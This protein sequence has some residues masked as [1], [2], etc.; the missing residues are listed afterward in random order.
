MEANGPGVGTAREVVFC[1]HWSTALVLNARV[2]SQTCY[3]TG[4][5]GKPLSR[6]LLTVLEHIDDRSSKPIPKFVN[7]HRKGHFS[8]LEMV[9]TLK[10]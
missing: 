10:G 7:L 3:S 5:W 4:R 8:P 1:V 9:L 6:F 2:F